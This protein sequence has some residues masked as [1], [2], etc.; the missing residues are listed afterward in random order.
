MPENSVLTRWEQNAESWTT[1][2]LAD[3]DVYRDVLNTPAFLAFLPDVVGLKGLDIG[4]G[5]AE[6]TR[7][8]ARKGARMYGI[9]FAPIFIRYAREA[10]Q[11]APLNV[12]FHLAD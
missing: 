2:A 10:E 7:V 5:E 4:C 9:D 12:E 8:L 11:H 3:C 1:L 6:N